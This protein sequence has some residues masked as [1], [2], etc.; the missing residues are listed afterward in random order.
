MSLSALLSPN[1]KTQYQKWSS[2]KLF[3]GISSIGIRT[4]GDC[5]GWLALAG[6]FWRMWQWRALGSRGQVAGHLLRV[7]RK[8]RSSSDSI[9][10]PHRLCLHLLPLLS[11]FCPGPSIHFSRDSRKVRPWPRNR[12][13]YKLGVPR[14]TAILR[15]K[16]QKNSFSRLEDSPPLRQCWVWHRPVSPDIQGS[17]RWWQWL[18][19]GRPW[20]RC[21]VAVEL[22]PVRGEHTVWK[23]RPRYFELW[24]KCSS[25]GA[26]A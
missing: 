14:Q 3:R 18:S 24:G 1:V 5:D 16:A 21:L 15:W 7:Y 23:L 17:L 10:S 12:S 20:Q 9:V 8:K 22:F 19:W 4:K 6:E 11:P 25:W 13:V 26:M 2:S